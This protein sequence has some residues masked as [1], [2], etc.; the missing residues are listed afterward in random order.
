M[1]RTAYT[2]HIEFD[3]YNNSRWD[4]T[5][6]RSNYHFDPCAETTDYIEVC[7]FSGNWEFSVEQMLDRVVEVNWA[8]RNSHLFGPRDKKKPV[9][10]GRA[11]QMD[12]LKAGANPHAPIFEHCIADDQE[13]F[14]AMSTQ[15]GL[16]DCDT[17]FKNQRTGHMFHLHIDNLAG[18]HERGNSFKVTKM[19]KEPETIRRFMIALDDWRFGQV[20]TFG[21]EIW[22]HWRKGDCVTWDWYNVPYSWMNAGWDA[23]PMLQLTGYTTPQTDTV[24]KNSHKHLNIIKL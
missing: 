9:Y 15:L 7:Q 18:R 24:L 13:P 23:C 8:N 20:M 14:I 11:E 4:F 19:D 21:T 12:L 22:S 2:R 1:R 17:M 5:T 6:K 16:T 10:S 3:N